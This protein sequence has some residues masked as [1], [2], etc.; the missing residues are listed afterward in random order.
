MPS[1]IKSAQ[2]LSGF[3]L[4]LASI[5]FIAVTLIITLLQNQSTGSILI[6]IFVPIFLIILLEASVYWIKQSFA[7]KRENMQDSREKGAISQSASIFALLSR[8]GS[9]FQS[10]VLVLVLLA[11][12]GS[13]IYYFAP[14]LSQGIKFSTQFFITIGI[15]LAYFLIIRRF[16]KK[17]V[18]KAGKFARNQL[19]SCSLENDGLILN[20]VFKRGKSGIF[21]IIAFVAGIIGFILG[22]FGLQIPMYICIGIFILFFLIAV[23]GGKKDIRVYPVKIK[24]SEIQE[25]KE[26]SFIEVQ[27]YMN[28]KIGPDI[29]LQSQSIMDM[30]NFLKD[31]NNPENRPN[32]YT[33]VSESSGAKTL[34]IRGQN[35][36]YLIAVGNEDIDEI[37]NQVQKRIKI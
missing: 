11:F 27:S 6:W 18:Y 15:Y 22:K 33:L 14:L 29:T 30:I 3:V 19:P 37:V 12:I 35:L 7:I 28:Y 10:V 24:F 26:L 4:L 16:V 34:L 23:F 21:I 25:I 13:G 9:I 5:F 1:T 36:F 32:T 8:S 20:L 2:V 31:P 17:L